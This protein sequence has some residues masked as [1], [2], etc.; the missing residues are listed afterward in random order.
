MSFL[1]K[2][3]KGGT[4]PGSALPQATRNIHTSDGTTGTTVSNGLTEGVAR[5]L[6]SPPPNASSDTS[7]SSLNGPGQG[8]NAPFARRDRAESDLG[9]S[10]FDNL[11]RSYTDAY[12]RLA[13][14]LSTDS[15]PLTL[16][17]TLGLRADSIFKTFSKTLFRGMAPLS[18]RMLLRTGI[19][20]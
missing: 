18:T 12:L 1:F 16:P 4:Q 6:Q 5:S 3:K 10:V 13:L 7:I 8:S 14:Q 2:S 9:V 17:S 19:Y 11:G 20:T 15:H